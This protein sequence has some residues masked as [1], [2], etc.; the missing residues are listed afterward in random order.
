MV[1]WKVSEI[2]RI[3]LVCPINLFQPEYIP[4]RDQ[5]LVYLQQPPI[6]PIEI[7]PLDYERYFQPELSPEILNQLFVRSTKASHRVWTEF[8]AKVACPP[9]IGTTKASFHALWDT[10]IIRPF[11]FGYPD[12]VH[13]RN[14]SLHTST[15]K[16]RPDLSYLVHDACLA[17]GEEKAPDTDSDLAEELTEKLTWTYGKCPYIFGYHARATKVTYCYMYLEEKRVLRKDFLTCDLKT[18]QGRLQ[19]FIY[20]INIGRLLPLLRQTLPKYFLLHRSNGKVVECK[21]LS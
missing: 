7:H 14:S 3:E 12:G 16:L 20:G 6:K 9:R 11:T 19:A 10:L 21:M 1:S 5:L 13:N 2:H 8:I 17:R 18:V 15:R 4:A